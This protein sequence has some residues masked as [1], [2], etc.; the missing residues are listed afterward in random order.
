MGHPLKH[1]D[2]RPLYQQLGA[3]PTNEHRT[4]KPFHTRRLKTKTRRMTA[5]GAGGGHV[6][7]AQKF[8]TSYKLPL[9]TPKS[10]GT[11]PCQFRWQSA[12]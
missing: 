7:Y 6:S 1:Q 11:F 3:L 4:T 9:A 2:G 12:T 5:A 8:F 10:C